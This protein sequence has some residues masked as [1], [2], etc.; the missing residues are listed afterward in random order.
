[1]RLRTRAPATTT[2]TL[3]PDSQP[4]TPKA[5][6]SPTSATALRTAAIE[7]A[8]ACMSLA[9]LHA[10]LL[11]A[12]GIDARKNA[13]HIVFGDGPATADIMIIGAAPEA[14]E[15]RAG[16][17]F[18]G[19]NAVL[20]ERMLAAIGIKADDVY[21]TVMLN[22]RPA[23]GRSPLEHEIAL[24]LPYLE[25]HIALCNP[26]HLLIMG[27]TPARSLLGNAQS[28]AR[29]R[30]KTHTYRPQTEGITEGLDQCAPE[31]TA[32][33]LYAPSF[34]LNS[35]SHKAQMWADLLMIKNKL[36]D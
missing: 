31:R 13:T 12:D 28:I 9:D 24:S 16:K 26:K 35:P 2:P 6:T 5:Q 7:S 23:G 1:M 8:K 27:Q 19:A 36:L 4:Q 11:Q 22:W 33:A 18:A 20:L 32:I 21:K 15:D 25:R 30:G 17:P 34:L 10:A 3:V 29:L 14:D